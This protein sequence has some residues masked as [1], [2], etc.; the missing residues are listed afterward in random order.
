MAK[1]GDQVQTCNDPAP[2]PTCKI[3]GTSTVVVA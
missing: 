2:A 1:V 3:V